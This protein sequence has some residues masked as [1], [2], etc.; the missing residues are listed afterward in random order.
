MWVKIVAIG[1]GGGVGSVLRYAVAG[2]VQKPGGVSF[3]AGTLAVNVV[4]CL[5][6]GF[7]AVSLSGPVLVREEVRLALLVGVLGGFTTFSSFAWE[8]IALASERQAALAALNVLASNVLG[9][10]AAWC[11]WR[12]ARAVFGV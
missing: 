10:A 5:L 8:T 7:L 11:G 2:W 9:F 1:V 12:I 4:G 3:P 6:I